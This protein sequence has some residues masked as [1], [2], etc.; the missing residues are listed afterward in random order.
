MHIDALSARRTNDILKIKLTT[1]FAIIRLFEKT[2]PPKI[3]DI[4]TPGLKN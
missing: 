4:Y 1:V 3:E 2:E